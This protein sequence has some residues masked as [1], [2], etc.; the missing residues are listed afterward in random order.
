[1]LPRA[2]RIWYVETSRIISYAHLSQRF[3]IQSFGHALFHLIVHPEY[4]EVLREEIKEVT[5]DS[6]L[7]RG[8]L[9]QMHKLDSFLRETQRFSGIGNREYRKL[10]PVLHSCCVF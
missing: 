1:M 6:E 9:D 10:Y 5:G 2:Q 7:T 4:I 8:S 3:C